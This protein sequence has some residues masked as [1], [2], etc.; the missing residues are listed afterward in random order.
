MRLRRLPH[1]G[2]TL[3]PAPTWPLFP[4]PGART[5][6]PRLRDLLT[7]RPAGNLGRFNASTPSPARLEGLGYWAPGPNRSSRGTQRP[8][9]FPR[10]ATPLMAALAGSRT[11]RAREGFASAWHNALDP[12]GHGVVVVA[13]TCPAAEPHEGPRT[14]RSSSPPASNIRVH[15]RWNGLSPLRQRPGRWFLALAEVQL[16]PL[17]AGPNLHVHANEDEMFFVLDG[18]MT[19]QVGDQP[20]GRF[21]FRDSDVGAQPKQRHAR[22]HATPTVRAEG[23]LPRRVPRPAQRALAKR[24]LAAIRARAAASVAAWDPPR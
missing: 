23:S 11:A 13:R 19:V 22:A 24:A 3:I 12:K 15:R 5:G 16:P 10:G 4:A 17:T 14:R 9:G 2:R 1:I 6:W 18:V 20:T 7:A 8:P 21:P